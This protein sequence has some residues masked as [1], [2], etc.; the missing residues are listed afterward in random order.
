MRYY[1]LMFLWVYCFSA[2]GQMSIKHVSLDYLFEKP[3]KIEWVKYY[4]GR[5]DDMNDIAVNL[6]YDGKFCKGELIYLRSKEKLHLVGTIKKNKLSFQEINGNRS[7][8]GYLNGEFTATGILGEWS[9]FDNTIAGKIVL[10][11]VSRPALVPTHCGDNKWI[12]LYSGLV[13]NEKVN[14][15]V[16]KLANENISG[17]AYFKGKHTSYYVSGNFD[18]FD[19][20]YIY[21]K[22]NYIQPFG[23]FEGSLGDNQTFIATYFPEEGEPLIC[24]FR[25]NE[26]MQIDCSEYADY[27]SSYDIIFPS[28]QNAFFHQWMK[29]LTNNWINSCQK[30]LED[31]KQLNP[32]Q[33]PAM[34]YSI[35][36]N[37]WCSIDYFSNDLVSGLLNCSTTW[38]EK[39][40]HKNINFDLTTG[41]EITLEDVFKT[42]FDYKALIKK[43][44]HK[45][46]RK[47]KLYKQYHY[48]EWL[49]GET[50]PYFTLRKEGLNFY[51]DFNPIYG[52]QQITIP[53]EDLASFIKADSPV[54][55]IFMH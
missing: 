52:Q 14:L 6:A 54:K 51:T 29:T 12:R 50:F 17:I 26:T 22:D 15:I 18:Q 30:Y 24:S 47:Y 11:E 3:K 45:E 4:Q 49:S 31:V 53:Y 44:L 16:H 46:I 36:A 7:L 25:L 42:D 33:N 48:R 55:K 40:E 34:R 10:K 32:D 23:K 41:R 43:R 13:G 38:N 5:I 2:S 8:S 35:R 9:N 19:N 39:T 1:I 20:L 27:S 37:A 28:I 21:L